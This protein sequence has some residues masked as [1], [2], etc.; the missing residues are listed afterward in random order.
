MAGNPPAN[1]S[2]SSRWVQGDLFSQPEKPDNRVGLPLKAL[3]RGEIVDVL[4]RE[5]PDT[6]A[7]RHKNSD[8][9]VIVKESELTYLK[10]TNRRRPK[11]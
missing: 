8:K 2:S 6:I 3:H 9:W 7:I 5:S 11:V 10:N 4:H 1:R